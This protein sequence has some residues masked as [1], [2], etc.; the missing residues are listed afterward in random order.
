MTNDQRQ[1]WP[2]GAS[3]EY[4]ASRMELAR[5]E[6]RLRDQIEQVAAARRRLPP[7][8]VMA[9]YAFREGPRDLGRDGPVRQTRLREL[10]GRHDHLVIYH[11][12]FHPGQDQAC[13]MCSMWVDGLHGVAHHL[14]QHASFAVIG[15]APLPA[16][17]D[18]ARRRGWD[19]LRILSSF[20][21]TFNADLRVETAAGEQRPAVSV[22]SREGEGV[23]HF[24]TLPADLHDGAERGIDQ[25]C[26]VWG[27]L[28]LLPSGRGD[29]YASNSYAGRERR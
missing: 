1:A 6:R 22:F 24:S 4:V 18:W 16:L 7:G 21:N 13:P 20:E 8:A 29:W 2:D 26:P 11:L 25:L 17:R 28:D 9:D 23:R 10:F 19:G 5:A 15:K 12:M 3:A 27:V 14:A